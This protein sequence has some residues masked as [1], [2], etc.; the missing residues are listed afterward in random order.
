MRH[1]LKSLA[2]FTVAGISSLL[3]R[4]TLLE[5]KGA[6]Y[7][8]TSGEF[9]DIYSTGGMFGAEASIQTWR[10]LYTWTSGSFFIKEGRSIGL[11]NQT[12]IAFYPL[13]VGIKYLFPVSW[14]D[15]YLGGG[16]LA[17]YMH[18]HDHSPGVVQK[19]CRWGG[20]GIVKGGVIMTPFNR[21]F[22]FDFFTDY[23]FLYVPVEKHHGLYRHRADLSG[24]SI[25]LGIGCKLGNLNKK[26]KNQVK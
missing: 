24:W 17:V 1:L 21:R 20:G 3:A 26:T 11:K 19:T 7:Y 18:I 15:F 9:R 14:A 23:S 6:F 25:G 12:R 22:F 2:F 16:P 13:G 8:P 10:Q 5:V 4:E